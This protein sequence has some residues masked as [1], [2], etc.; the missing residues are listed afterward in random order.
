MIDSLEPAVL[1]GKEAETNGPNSK[2]IIK[3]MLEFAM[4]GALKAA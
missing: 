2:E 4:N 3:I 1:S